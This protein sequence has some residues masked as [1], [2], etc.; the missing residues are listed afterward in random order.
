M[1]K[2]KARSRKRKVPETA[3]RPLPTYSKIEVDELEYVALRRFFDLDVASDKA[4]HT[5]PIKQ[6]ERWLYEMQLLREA[7]ALLDMRK[8]PPP[9]DR[10]ILNGLRVVI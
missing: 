2:T 7:I 3:P 4:G 9:K 10:G 8:L 1:S 5:W 6:V